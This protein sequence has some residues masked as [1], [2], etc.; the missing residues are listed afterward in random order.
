MTVYFVRQDRRFFPAFS[1]SRRHPGSRRHAVGRGGLLLFAW[2]R[3]RKADLRVTRDAA[4]GVAIGYAGMDIMP[5][6]PR[7]SQARLAL[8]QV[9]RQPGT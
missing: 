8:K 1:L 3:H 9:P 4:A 6:N 5:E 7:R 2:L